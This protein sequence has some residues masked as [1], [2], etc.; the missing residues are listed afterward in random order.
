MGLS[1]LLSAKQ[2]YLD[3]VSII[4]LIERPQHLHAIIDTL[5]NEFS[6][7]SIS[8][9]TSELAIAEC[10]VVPLRQRNKNLIDRFEAFFNDSN[11][12]C[13]AL[14]KLI[15]R[16]AAQL[17]ADVPSVRLPDAIHLSTAKA[18]G[19]MAFLTND[20]RIHQPPNLPIYFLSQ[21]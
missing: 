12:N 21:L 1:N 14:S 10:L 9:L 19:A 13:H 4:S 2:I 3:S 5:W 17:R 16:E 8:F 20:L 6:A 18:T 11:I 15:L 7:G